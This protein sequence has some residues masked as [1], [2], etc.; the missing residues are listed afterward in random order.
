MSVEYLFV[1]EE[2]VGKLSGLDFST[3]TFYRNAVVGSIDGGVVI[4]VRESGSIALNPKL[5][6][7][8]DTKEMDILVPLSK[9]RK[10]WAKYLGV[11]KKLVDGELVPY[12]QGK[13]VVILNAPPN[14]GKDYFVE[15]LKERDVKKIGGMSW[16]HKELKTPLVELVKNF[17]S[18][19]DKDVEHLSS[20]ENKETPS[21]LLNGKSWREAVIHVS[22]I[23]VKPAL[24]KDIFGKV[25]AI[26]LSVG[27]N[28]FTD[29][30]F[31]EELAPIVEEVGEDNIII[32]KIHKD[33]CSFE[34]DS[35]DWIDIE[36]VNSFD[37]TNYGDE[38]FVEG[39]LYLID[40]WWA[41]REHSRQ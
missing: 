32:V 38:S 5:P 37:V 26:N 20:R 30:G 39:M 15:Q 21:S 23:V 35:R 18:L 22:E 1:S 13:K 29:G 2:N 33:G 14:S 17:Y 8:M 16:S 10:G 34:G 28:I 24:G 19:S 11:E 12:N 3:V 36:G 40:K 31:E 6:E 7:G 27:I 25:A 4:P 9:D 41:Y